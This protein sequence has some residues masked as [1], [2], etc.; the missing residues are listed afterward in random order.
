M[1]ET[2]VNEGEGYILAGEVEIGG[3]YYMPETGTIELKLSDLFGVQ[4]GTTATG[5]QY[6]YAIPADRFTLPENTL[7]SATR[8]T[9]TF[10]CVGLTLTKSFLVSVQKLLP[11]LFDE[12]TILAELNA[13]STVSTSDVNIHQAYEEVQRVAGETFMTDITKHSS[14]NRLV[15]LKTLMNMLPTYALKLFQIKKIDDHSETRFKFDAD[16]LNAKLSSE[17]F[18]ILAREYDYTSEIDTLLNLVSTT[19]IITGEGV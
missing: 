15:Y 13:P 7:V 12:N 17:Y 9:M 1:R 2:I 8:I 6:P 14:D 16:Q 19:D 5:L 10:D 3:Q 11:V 18:T 4:I